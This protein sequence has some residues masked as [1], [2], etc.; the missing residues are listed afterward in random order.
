MDIA[1]IWYPTY[2][3]SLSHLGCSSLRRRTLLDMDMPPAQVLLLVRC[4]G[5]RQLES[6]TFRLQKA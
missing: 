5:Q 4:T 1:L 2:P 6:Y 3:Q